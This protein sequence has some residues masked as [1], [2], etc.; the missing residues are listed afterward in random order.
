MDTSGHRKCVLITEYRGV[1][2]SEVDLYTKAYH[3]DLRNCPVSLFQRC[4]LRER[5][6]C[7]YTYIIRISNSRYNIHGNTEL[8]RIPQLLHYI[9]RI[10]TYII[11]ALTCT[12][13]TYVCCIQARNEGN[14]P[15]LDKHRQ[16]GRYACSSYIVTLYMYMSM[17]KLS[18][19]TL[20]R[21]YTY[22]CTYGEGY[23]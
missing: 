6:H 4:P 8:T 3:W 7:V 11:C 21:S 10:N 1:L 16:D 12:Y 20:I 15:Q 13:V 17:Y 22:S 19:K 23:V 5:F 9:L 2:I 18:L 14:V